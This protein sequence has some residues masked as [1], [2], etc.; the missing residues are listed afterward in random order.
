MWS[1]SCVGKAKLSLMFDGLFCCFRCIILYILFYHLVPDLELQRAT[2]HVLTLLSCWAQFC[3]EKWS[4]RHWRLFGHLYGK[5][6]I[7]L[8][9][10]TSKCACFLF[11]FGTIQ[12]VHFVFIC[13][14]MFYVAWQN[15]EQCLILYVKMG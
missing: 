12:V 7:W 3:A 5:S 4:R 2:L 14:I 9:L 6:G 15:T 10:G 1:R 8:Y 13:M 11:I